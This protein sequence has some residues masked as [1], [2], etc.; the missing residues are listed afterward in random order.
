[1]SHKIRQLQEASRGGVHFSSHVLSHVW[2]GRAFTEQNYHVLEF[3][4]I[5]SAFYFSKSNEKQANIEVVYKD[6][7]AIAKIHDLVD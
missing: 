6:H 4:Q 1:M 3:K 2:W 7:A 5:Q